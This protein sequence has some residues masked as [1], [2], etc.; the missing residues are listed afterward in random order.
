TG[1][2]RAGAAP[3]PTGAAAKTAG[4]ASRAA[5][6]SGC[7]VGSARRR[8]STP[9]TRSGCSGARDAERTAALI[10]GAEP[11]LTWTEADPV[12]A[13]TSTEAAEES[14]LTEAGTAGAETL[15]EASG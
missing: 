7:D 1:C 3:T 9:S 2:P 8:V 10:A 12:G 11:A 13:S 14:T 4:G 5:T 6:G 15:T